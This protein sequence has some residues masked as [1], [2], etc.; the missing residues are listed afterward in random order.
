MSAAGWVLAAGGVAAANEVV[1]APIEGHGTPIGNFNWRLIPATAIL[2][3]TLTGFEK[4]APDFGNALGMLAF[5]VVLVAPMGKAPTP[6]DNAS[7]II[8]GKKA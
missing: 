5:L 2:A 7:S 8:S 6:L 1:F 3:L 4:L